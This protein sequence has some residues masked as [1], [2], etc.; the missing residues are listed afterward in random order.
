MRETPRYYVFVGNAK[1]EVEK[2]VY[3][4]LNINDEFYVHIARHSE[5]VL[6]VSKDE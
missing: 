1:Y 4:D 6:N 3:D 5:T 2:D